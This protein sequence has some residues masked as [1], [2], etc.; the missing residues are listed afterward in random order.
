[1]LAPRDPISGGLEVEQAEEAG[2]DDGLDRHE[3]HKKGDKKAFAGQNSSKRH[4]T[5]SSIDG[6]FYDYLSGEPKSTW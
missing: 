3:S 2:R 1:M 5:P 6:P 4:G